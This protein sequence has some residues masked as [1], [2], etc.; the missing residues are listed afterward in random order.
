MLK[1]N[2]PKAIY[3]LSVFI[4]ILSINIVKYIGLNGILTIPEVICLKTT[5]STILF[6][7]FGIKHCLELKKNNKIDKKTAVYILIFGIISSASSYT[8]NIGVQTIKMNNAMILLFLSPIITVF[9]AHIILNEKITKK[10]KISFPINLTAVFLIYKF[11]FDE[12]NI[13]YILLL[14]DFFLYAFVN[15]L[16]KKLKMLPTSFLVFIRFLVLLP[17]SWLVI[18][19]IPEM[20]LKV[21]ILISL[22]TFGHI[23]ERTLVTLTFKSIPVSEVQPLRYSYLVFSPIISF[24]ILNEPLTLYQIAAIAIIVIGAFVVNKIKE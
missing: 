10:I 15:I 13:G 1:F 21:I 12:F 20:N 19:K 8:W 7:P 3:L 11:S 23:C 4:N 22:I 5:L 16:I 18:D 6:F 17:I 2:S 9:M 24:L 14:A